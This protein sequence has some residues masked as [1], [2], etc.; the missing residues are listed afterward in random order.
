MWWTVS[1]IPREIRTQDY[2][3]PGCRDG[4]GTSVTKVTADSNTSI[5]LTG[6]TFTCS[7][8]NAYNLEFLGPECSLHGGVALFTSITDSLATWNCPISTVLENSGNLEA[9]RIRVS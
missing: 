2:K 9:L 7:S 6:P 3:F 1:S 8:R 4:T 5:S